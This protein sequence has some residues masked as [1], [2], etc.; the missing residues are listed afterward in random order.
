MARISDDIWFKSVAL[1]DHLL[2]SLGKESTELSWPWNH[3]ASVCL[4]LVSKLKAPTYLLAH[5]FLKAVNQTSFYK[6]T[7]ELTIENVF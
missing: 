2:Y 6:K 1:F 4:Y 5:T 7:C 3:I